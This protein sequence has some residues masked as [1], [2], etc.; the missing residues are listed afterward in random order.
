MKNVGADVRRLRLKIKFESR[1][2]VSYGVR[3]IHL[4]GVSPSIIYRIGQCD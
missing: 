3:F 4:K 1:H 2:L